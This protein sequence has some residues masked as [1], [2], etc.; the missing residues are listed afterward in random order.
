MKVI[1]KIILYC[2]VIIQLSSCAMVGGG[3]VENIDGGTF[4]T[5]VNMWFSADRKTSSTNLH[6]GDILPVGTEVTV[7]SAGLFGIKFKVDSDELYILKRVERHCSISLDKLFKRYF[8]K[9]D[10]TSSMGSYGKFTPKEQDNVDEGVISEGM[11]K[12]SVL[13]AYGFPPSHKTPLLT[14][15][16][17]FYWAGRN[18][19]E[20]FFENDR[21]KKIIGVQAVRAI[22]I[23]A[24]S[25]P[26]GAAIHLDGRFLGNTPCIMEVRV[27]ARDRKTRLFRAVPDVPKTPRLGVLCDA[28]L[29]AESLVANPIRVREVIPLSSGH[30]LG[31]V[32]GDKIIAVNSIPIKNEMDCMRAFHGAGFGRPITMRIKRGGTDIDLKGH[33]ESQEKGQ[34]Y[35]KEERISSLRLIEMDGKVMFFNLRTAST[36]PVAAL[37]RKSRQPQRSAR[38]PEIIR[39]AVNLPMAG[40]GFIVGTGG[41]VVTCASLVKNAQRIILLSSSGKKHTASVVHTDEVNDWCLLKA[42]S[43]SGKGILVAPDIS[44]KT[45]AKIYHIGYPLNDP[46][47][48]ALQTGSGQLS[49]V[50]GFGGD[51]RHLQVKMIGTVGDITGSPLLDEHGRWMGIISDKL[52]DMIHM[53]TGKG[54]S[55]R[56]NMILLKASVIVKSLPPDVVLTASGSEASTGILDEGSVKARLAASIVVIYAKQ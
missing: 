34:F 4:F 41:Y 13:M 44:I 36:V 46:K 32:P 11:T 28:P 49:H 8:G 16:K 17:W 48:K 23:Y 21:L 19:V 14:A 35:T 39:P 51:D 56:D 22:K 1:C 29:P 45:G 52:N 42:S 24:V 53:F 50:Q 7:V 9:N 12:E 10:I 20:V 5:K 30:K 27:A 25:D 6:H 38:R 15:D 2:A 33:T 47:R 3:K 31:L 37:P 40:T 55:V 18:R 54:K 43:L 26:S